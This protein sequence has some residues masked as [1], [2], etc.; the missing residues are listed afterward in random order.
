M[1]KITE[2]IKKYKH[3]FDNL[4]FSSKALELNFIVY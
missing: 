4:F 3:N 2:I 1:K